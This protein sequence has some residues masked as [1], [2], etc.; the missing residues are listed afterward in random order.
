MTGNASAGGKASGKDITLLYA[1]TQ[2]NTDLQ[3]SDDFQP[4]SSFQPDDSLPQNANSRYRIK[5]AIWPKKSRAE[6][7]ESGKESHSTQ[8][9]NKVGQIDNN[10][11]IQTSS[12]DS[13]GNGQ[14]CGQSSL[15]YLAGI[16]HLENHGGIQIPCFTILTQGASENIAF[17]HNRMPVILP[18]NFLAVWLNPKVNAE[19]II[20][21][22]EK[23]MRAMKVMEYRAV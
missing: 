2:A 20:K 12:Q 14:T 4:D 13:E 10:Q 16:Y 15:F 1:N 5:Y 8:G 6:V 9:S 22:A 3:P 21:N 23:E 7:A 11:G 18:H 17:I 19:D